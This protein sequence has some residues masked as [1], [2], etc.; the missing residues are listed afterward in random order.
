MIPK[1]D[2]P[3]HQAQLQ[4]VD[5]S[6]H[7]LEHQLDPVTHLTAGLLPQVVAAQSHFHTHTHKHLALL[8][9]PSGVLTQVQM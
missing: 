6:H 3:S 4:L 5:Q 1:A 9:M 2:L 8:Y 7:R